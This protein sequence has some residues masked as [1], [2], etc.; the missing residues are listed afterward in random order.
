MRKALA[1]AILF[2]FASCLSYDS[3]SSDDDIASDNVF[4]L[5]N[6]V[7]T[8]ADSKGEQSACEGILW[9]PESQKDGK[10]VILSR[11]GDVLQWSSICVKVLPI[12]GEPPVVEFGEYT[13][14]EV[15]SKGTSQVWRFSMPGSAYDGRYEIEVDG[16]RCEGIVADPA[17]RND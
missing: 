5:D 13:G 8:G 1:L 4:V 10:L 11:P 9:K 16:E 6:S 14:T 15:F 7:Q 12:D 2:S 3:S 17:D